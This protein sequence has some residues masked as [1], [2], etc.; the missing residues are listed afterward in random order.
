MEIFKT[1][2]FMTALMLL[3]IF[4]GGLVGGESG[5]FIALA[6]GAMT[7]LVS[8]FF[9]DTMVLKHYNATQLEPENRLYRLVEDLAVEANL[10]M[11]K[12]YVIEDGALN[13]FATGRNHKHAVVAVTR[14][15]LEMMDDNEVKAVVAHEL[16]HV[17]HYDILTGT[18]ASVFAGAIASLATMLKFGAAGSMVGGGGG[19]R[20]GANPLFLLALAVVAPT[21]ATVIQMSVSRAREFEA[22]KFSAELTN[23][24]WLASALGRIEECARRVA[25]QNANE[26]TAHMFIISPLSGVTQAFSGLFRTHP[27]TEQ[28]IARLNEMAKNGVG[29]SAAKRYFQKT[30]N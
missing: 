18:I 10:P 29:S 7:N 8:Y 30:E 23:P 19:E 15:L 24:L 26:Q 20:R 5:V 9:S 17:K 25:M 21:V 14:G 27:T 28:R 11:P 1:A 16:G 2:F 4:I 22:D 12:L 13:A 3:F 6:V